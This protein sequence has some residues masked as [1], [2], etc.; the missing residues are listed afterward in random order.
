MTT[1]LVF[2]PTYNEAG[3][4]ASLVAAIRAM[5]PRAHILAVD[6][7]SS[8]G[9]GQLLDNLARE[10][11][12]VTIIHRPRKLGIGTA[13]KLAMI[14]A[15]RLR[16]DPLI[17]MDADFS[18]HPRYLPQMAELIG[19]HDFVTGSRYT[20]GGQCD[21]GQYRTLLSRG[22]NVV[23]RS[24]LGL[25]LAE[26]TTA[27]RGFRLSVLDRL[28][29]DGIQSEG[30][31]FFV[32]S[33]YRIHRLGAN[34]AEF[35]IH[36]ENRRSGQSK[37]SKIEIYR[38]MLTIIRLAAKRFTGQASG[39]ATHRHGPVAAV[40]PSC[41]GSIH[42]QFYPPMGKPASTP[43]AY[44]CATSV[45]RTHG[46]ILQCLQCGLV[47]MPTDLTPD[48]LAQAYADV[49]DPTYLAHIQARIRT[50]DYNLKQIEPFLKGA[51]RLLDVGS[52]CGAFMQCAQK[53]GLDVVGLEPSRWAAQVSRRRADAPVITGALAQMPDDVGP[54]DIITMWDVL[55]HFIDPAAELGHI[56]RLL[57]DNG[58]L[59]FSTLDISNWF[60]R[61]CGRRWPWY[62][63]MHLTYFTPHTLAD[64]L[65]RNGF[66]MVAAQPYC[67]I[68][69]LDYL[70]TKLASLGIPGAG[71]LS[72]KVGTTKWGQ[73]MIAFKF[74]DIKWFVCQKSDSP[75]SASF[76]SRL[77]HDE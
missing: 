51:R 42:T 66:E 54:F 31:S 69:T 44:V 15:R 2:F 46:R 56:H 68:I 28:D 59:I 24:A 72:V 50:F 62:M 3:N 29:L 55:E 10:H 64:L 30:Y 57:D 21:Y 47:F 12:N 26:N 41:R 75:F 33:L 22:A 14:Y 32:E 71:R 13:H 8:D 36:F 65:A 4:V 63:P 17:T 49:Q 67:H 76:K 19:N 25:P 38:A 34:L 6:D 60:A 53:Q 20:T 40:C 61:A 52:Y 5:L 45:K 48:A 9:T 35:P 77:S 1:T 37:I 43:Q 23:A 74:G 73:R 16:F 18:H 58:K 7:A 70:L 39:H 11:S 27:F